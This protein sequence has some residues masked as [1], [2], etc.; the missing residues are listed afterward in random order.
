MQW[1]SAEPEIRENSK[2]YGMRV[3]LHGQAT[4]DSQLLAATAA[5]LVNSSSEETQPDD[6]A[7]PQV[8]T[9]FGTTL[10]LLQIY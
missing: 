6:Q 7:S 3:I 9:E 8:C 1:L 5:E 4:K 2:L 10:P